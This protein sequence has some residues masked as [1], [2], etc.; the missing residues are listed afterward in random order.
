[1]FLKQKGLTLIEL[2]LVIAIIG[3]LLTI[4]VPTYRDHAIKARITEGLTMA[5]AAKLAVTEYTM[6]NHNLPPSQAAAGYTSPASTANVQSIAIEPKGVIAISYTELA[7]KGTILLVPAMGAGGEITWTCDK[8]T[9]AKQYRP[10][11]CR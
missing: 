11:S 7:G 6:T 5:E 1:M 9:L 3:I 10:A 8:G 2:M 4:A